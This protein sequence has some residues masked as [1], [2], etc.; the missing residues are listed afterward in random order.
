MRSA[1][2]IQLGNV[3]TGAMGRIVFASAF[4]SRLDEKEWGRPSS[5]FRAPSGLHQS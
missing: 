4:S 1:A 3:M 5:R 2:Q